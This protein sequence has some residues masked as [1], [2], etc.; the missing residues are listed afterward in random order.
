MITGINSVQLFG[1]SRQAVQ[2]RKVASPQDSAPSLLSHPADSIAFSHTPKASN[3]VRFSGH[4]EGDD[5]VYSDGTRK[6]DANRPS[7]SSS[8]PEGPSRRRNTAPNQP[9]QSQPRRPDPKGKNKQEGGGLFDGLMDLGRN[10]TKHAFKKVAE[11]QAHRGVQKVYQDFAPENRHSHSIHKTYAPMAPGAEPPADVRYPGDLRKRDKYRDRT[12]APQTIP[13]VHP[14]HDNL[15]LSGFDTRSNSSD[16]DGYH[17]E[18]ITHYGPDGK[19]T[20][21]TEFD[22]K[23]SHRRHRR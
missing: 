3:G 13:G 10:A 1:K 7:R 8:R 16:D 17:R 19:A 11:E 21:L 4:W 14:D 22:S 20:G 18:D 12:Y 15:G 23:K 5:Y 6:L 9:S 2:N